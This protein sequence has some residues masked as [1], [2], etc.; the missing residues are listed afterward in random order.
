M[1]LIEIFAEAKLQNTQ[2]LIAGIDFTYSSEQVQKKIS[3]SKTDNIHLIGPRFGENKHK[4][5]SEVD[6]YISLSHKEN[7]SYTAAEALNAGLPVILS[8]GNDLAGDLNEGM[9]WLLKTEEKSEVIKAL[10]EFDQ[11]S[12]DRLK[13]MSKNAYNW[14]LM[15]LS[16]SS[17]KSQ[18]N[19]LTS[20]RTLP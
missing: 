1:E 12:E 6:G 8:P 18:V 19:E 7:F 10:K 20:N 5:Y 9:G 3:E 4:L 2:L 16:S 15:H 17:F 14:A 13:I 11:I